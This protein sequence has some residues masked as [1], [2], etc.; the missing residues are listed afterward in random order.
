[1]NSCE[2]IFKISAI[3]NAISSKLTTDELNLLATIVTQ[4]GD[5]LNTI[6]AQRTYCDS[7][8]NK[9]TNT[10]AN[11]TTNTNAT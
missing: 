6:V 7:L 5:T 8:N 4:L 9:S 2:L 10:N 11:N 3:A 1:M